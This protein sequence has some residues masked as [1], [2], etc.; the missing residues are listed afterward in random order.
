MPRSL[1][2]YQRKRDFSRTPEPAGTQV[3]SGNQRFVV[4]KHWATR[5]HYDFRLEMEGVLIS[6]AIPKGPTLNPAERRLAA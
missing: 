1:K 4:Q 2:E 6:W 5:L 3:P